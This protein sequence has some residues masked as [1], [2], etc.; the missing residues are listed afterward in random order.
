[1]RMVVVVY[2]GGATE[3]QKP[4]AI[5]GVQKGVVAVVV[6]T[7]CTMENVLELGYRNISRNYRSST[8]VQSV[9]IN[10]GRFLASTPEKADTSY[11][12]GLYL[13]HAFYKY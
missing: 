10:C 2:I 6:Q 3:H 7:R 11:G 4:S 13:Y 5:G 12:N 1:M 8:D 9:S